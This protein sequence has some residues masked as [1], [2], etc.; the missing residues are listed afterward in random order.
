MSLLSSRDKVLQTPE[1]TLLT[2]PASGPVS[3][4]KELSVY[5]EVTTGVYRRQIAVLDRN[6]PPNPEVLPLSSFTVGK[7]PDTGL[8]HDIEV[9]G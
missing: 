2:S 6:V 5:R 7:I 3:S 4:T 9:V 1:S 8:D